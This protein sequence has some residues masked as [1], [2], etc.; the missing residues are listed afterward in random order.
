MISV[1]RLSITS[2]GMTMFSARRPSTSLGD[3]PPAQ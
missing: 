2:S 3:T 1:G